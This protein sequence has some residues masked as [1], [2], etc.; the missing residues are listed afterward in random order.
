M[1]A[2]GKVLVFLNLVFA[3]LTGGLI[4]M[5]FLTRTNW[6]NAYQAADAAAKAQHASYQ[7]LLA[8]EQGQVRA[9]EQQVKDVEKVR[10]EL[11]NQLNLARAELEQAKTQLAAVTRNTDN[12]TVTTQTTTAE[13]QRRQAEIKA[14]QDTLAA[15]DTRIRDLERQLTETRNESVTNKLNLDALRERMQTVLAQNQELTQQMARAQAGGGR[16]GPGNVVPPENVRGQVKQVD[17]NLV[18]IS[19]GTDAGVNRDN[20]LYVY[21]LGTD[22]RY[23][24]ELTILSATPFEAVGRFR[25]ASRSLT[26]RPGDEVGSRILGGR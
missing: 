4:G 26:P 18:T 9:K 8:D 1:T 13:L 23:L 21:R 6:Y 3:L 15:R 12:A 22:P 2:F 25:P 14:F 5:A 19:V 11:T 7:Q 10:D 17:G 20:V 16:T 24:G